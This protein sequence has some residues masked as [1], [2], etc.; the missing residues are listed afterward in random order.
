MSTRSAYSVAIF[1]RRTVGPDAGKILV[2]HHKRLAT[3]LP[4]GGEIEAGE[5]PLQAATRELKE[6]TGLSGTFVPVDDAVDGSPPGLLGYEEHEA[7]SKGTHLNFCFL[8]DVDDSPLVAC[9]EYDSA[10]FVDRAEL[11]QLSCPANV[12]QLGLRA[13]A[14]GRVDAVGVAHA[15][16][17]A[18]NAKDLDALLG[19]YATGAVHISPKLRERR[20]ETGGQI[21]GVEALRAWWADAFERLPTLRYRALTV[22][23]EG[24][25]VFLEYVR[26]VKGQDD[27]VV[28]ERYDLGPAGLIVRSH[29]FHG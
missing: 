9:D 14:G 5:T 23:G 7:G 8:V 19:L 17:E 3:W 11:L 21:V 25:S 12:R 18:F 29:V 10:R 27:L 4:V 26:E 13:L 22:I 28:A 2:I 6:E 24:R 16:L 15:W 1:V 20:P